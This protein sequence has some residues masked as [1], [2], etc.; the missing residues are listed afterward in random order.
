MTMISG[1]GSRVRGLFTDS[2]GPWGPSGSDGGDPPAPDDDGQGAG[3]WG[4]PPRRTRRPGLG[5][6]DVSAL[7][8]LIRRGRARF[9]GGGSGTGG[10][11]PGK[12]DRSL[13]LWG[14]VGFI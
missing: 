4:E 8:E 2:K 10:G 6:A 3:P 1:W 5:G 12:P 13:I 11:L 14:V 9:G 7:E